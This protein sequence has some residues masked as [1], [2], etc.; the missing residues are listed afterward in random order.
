MKS[1]V[2][3]TANS[4]EIKKV[5]GNANFWAKYL[6]DSQKSDNFAAEIEIN[7]IYVNVECILLRLLLL[8]YKQL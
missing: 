6:Q 3:G 8:L 7:E 2:S 1:V 5:S 4:C